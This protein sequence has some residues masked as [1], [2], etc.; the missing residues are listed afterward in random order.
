MTLDNL[1]TLEEAASKLKL[2]KAT[3]RRAIRDGK[4]EAL[5][6]GRGYR[7][8]EQSLQ[9]YVEKLIASRGRNNHD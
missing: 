9:D 1:L 8:S 2:N 7:V 3:L 4:L 6:L 5:W